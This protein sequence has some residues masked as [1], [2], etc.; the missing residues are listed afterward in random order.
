MANYTPK[1]T[2]TTVF[3][4]SAN[5][6]KPD[7]QDFLLSILCCCRR[8]RTWDDA[9]WKILPLTW[10]HGRQPDDVD[11]LKRREWQSMNPL[12]SLKRKIRSLTRHPLWWRSFFQHLNNNAKRNFTVG[13]PHPHQANE[14]NDNSFNTLERDLRWAK[15]AWKRATTPQQH[16]IYFTG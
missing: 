9:F 5:M 8:K 7:T 14:T 16:I 4:K 12:S 10:F 13:K 15:G 3:K 6:V 1:T 11:H 2:K